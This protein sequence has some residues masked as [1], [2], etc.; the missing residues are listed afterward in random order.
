MHAC[1]SSNLLAGAGRLQKGT[2]VP[3]RKGN[4]RANIG[5]LEGFPSRACLGLATRTRTSLSLCRVC[6]L[7]LVLHGC[8]VNSP[9]LCGWSPRCV[10]RW[11][12][13]DDYFKDDGAQHQY[14]KLDSTFSSPNNSFIP[15]FY[16]T[17]TPPDTHS[18]LHPSHPQGK[19][20]SRWLLE[21]EQHRKSSVLLA[22]HARN[23][24][25][26]RSRPPPHPLL[27]Q[28]P[29]AQCPHSEPWARS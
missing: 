18:P 19:I 11:R 2:S 10:A 12:D 5:A 17:P 4:G 27:C 23:Y 6:T 15:S 7:T 14:F 9:T 25:A 24:P 29:T 13:A 16:Q 26:M 20:K 22:P 3:A 28:L 21:S 1:G 8:R